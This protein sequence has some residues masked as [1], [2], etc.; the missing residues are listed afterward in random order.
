[1]ANPIE[2]QIDAEMAQGQHSQAPDPVAAS[3]DAEMQQAKFGS[4]PQAMIAGAEGLAK[5]VAGPLATIG[6][7]YLSKI[8]IPNLSSEE[9]E[10]RAKANPWV[11]GAA[12]LAGFV[13][14]VFTGTGQAKVLSRAG[15]AAIPIAAK[16]G[17]GGAGAGTLGKIGS[18]AVRGAVENGLYQAGDEVSRYINDPKS[19]ESAIPHIGL[20]SAIGGGLGIGGGAVSALW[21]STVG[22]DAGKILN[23]ISNHAGGIDGVESSA[24]HELAD[25]TGMDLAPEIKAGL[26]DDPVVK[27]MFNVLR[28][29]D[30]TNKGRAFQDTL[31]KFENETGNALSNSLGRDPVRIPEDFDKFSHGKNVGNTLAEEVKERVSPLKEAYEDFSNKY[32]GKELEPS[33]ASKALRSDEALNKANQE[34]DKAN[35]AA[36]KAQKLGDPEKA[37]AAATKVEEAQNALLD[38]Q[39]KAATPG[40]VDIISERLG[41]LAQEEKWTLAPSDEIMKTV[42]TIQKEVHNLKTLDD[43]SAY[44]KRI[45]EKMPF[46]PFNGSRNRA[47]GM[48]KGIFR[49]TEGELIGQHIGSEEGQAVLDGYRAT[50]KAY[51]AESKIKDELASRLGKLG[52]TASYAKT[53]KEMANTDAE[54]LLRKLSGKNDADVLRLLQSNFPKTAQALRESYLDQI[55]TKAKSGAELNPRAIMKELDKL[56]PQERAFVIP[57]ASAQRVEAIGQV[58]EKM[59]DA[60]FNFSS[61]ARTMDK[62]FQ[63]IPGSAVGM[64]S[65]LLGH[66]PLIGVAL[67]ALT[68][69]VSKDAPDAV[70]LGLLKWMGSNKP[71]EPGAFKSMVDMIHYTMKGDEV[72]SRAAR[73]VFGSGTKVIPEHLMPS[74]SK[75]NNLDKKLK[76]IQANPSK[77]EESGKQPGYYMPN[78][79]MAITVTASGA[80]SYLNSIRPKSVKTSPLD[81]P[82]EPSKIQE[83][84]FRRA[85][86]IAEQPLIVI[87]SMKKNTLTAQDVGH[88]KAMYP[89][90]YARLS[91]K[92]TDEM[93]D[94]VSKG[95]VIP[96]T[97]RM[98]LSTLL[99]QPL[100]SSLIPQNI[101]SNQAAIGVAVQKQQQEQNPK[102]HAKPSLTGMREMKTG[103]RLSLGR[104]DSGN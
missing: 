57:A 48:I 103:S 97:N 38:V 52:S 49:D 50:Q 98:G 66:S 69:Y 1:M 21:R 82:S 91:Q 34:L 32:K 101:M 58:V 13:A 51:G 75:I 4:V 18:T 67:G 43:I 9:Q 45:D 73:A 19:I 30:T 61:T 92:I 41:R 46:D 54:S 90:L 37:I 84:K 83:A 53:I 85:L 86:Q 15:E 39:N 89:Q 81:P 25:K 10:A 35:R 77:L 55:L 104:N 65:M 17:I 74:D 27:E 28:Q 63:Y 79:G 88:L 14:G 12:E 68:K 42:N 2:A 40:T 3:I 71:I 26:S 6:E 76:E 29:S 8:G 78:H 24:V 20:S 5:G 7:K 70:R 80:A 22:K 95:N 56:S 23:A 100:D 60:N 93:I 102:G 64:V 11:H 36:V 59:K 96:Y 62:L 72:T 44:I 16:L 87:E 94:H 47:A 33:V 31:K 99:G